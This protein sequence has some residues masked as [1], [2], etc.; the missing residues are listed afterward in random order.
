MLPH[1]LVGGLSF[2]RGGD[3]VLGDEVV[4]VHIEDC[5]RSEVFEALL[6]KETVAVFFTLRVLA[7]QVVGLHLVHVLLELILKLDNFLVSR[8][9]LLGALLLSF[10]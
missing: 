4:R 6:R 10:L 8:A 2:V 7:A 9:S 3:K 5:V 1:V